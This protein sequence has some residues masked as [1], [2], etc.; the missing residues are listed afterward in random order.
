MRRTRR[1][2]RGRSRCSGCARTRARGSHRRGTYRPLAQRRAD[3]GRTPERSVL[4]RS[5]AGGADDLR[6][7]E[8]VATPGGAGHCRRHAPSA[9]RR[10]CALRDRGASSIRPVWARSVTIPLRHG[11]FQRHRNLGCQRAHARHHVPARTAGKRAARAVEVRADRGRRNELTFT[12]TLRRAVGTPPRRP[13]ALHSR[14]Q[15]RGALASRSVH[16]CRADLSLG[17][18]LVRAVTLT[19]TPMADTVIIRVTPSASTPSRSERAS[20]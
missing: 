15:H 13:R 5:S 6:P 8:K 3:R 17:P 7:T 2:P 4:R 12:G 20:L 1:G 9:P 10:A 16:V 14:Q 18:L 19:P 11:L